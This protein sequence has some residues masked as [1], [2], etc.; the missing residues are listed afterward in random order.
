MSDEDIEIIS[1]PSVNPAD[2]NS[3]EGFC[4][5]LKDR[6]F[7]ELEKVAPAQILSYDRKTNRASVQI[8]NMGITSTGG[9]VP[10]QPLTDVPCLILQGG[11]MALSF[12]IKKD[13]IGW[14]VAA[15]RDISVFKRV[16]A[17]FAPNT[18]QKHKYKDSFFIPDKVE[19]FEISAE[20]ED[21]IL[22][23]STNGATKL[24]I[25]PDGITLTAD[26]TTVKGN[27]TITGETTAAKVIAQNGASGTFTNSVTVVNGI[28][29]GG[30]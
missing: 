6:I 8:L 21:A 12:P 15:D 13:D 11:G 19:G 29:I 24:S 14:I 30:S 27:L 22:L 26:T 4:D 28:V 7:L 1:T 5:F 20:D 9:T 17:M 10:K 3:L 16:L 23:T 2:V 25:K 18:Y